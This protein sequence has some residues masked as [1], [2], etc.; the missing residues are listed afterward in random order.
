M[1]SSKRTSILIYNLK[2]LA[3]FVQLFLRSPRGLLGIMLIGVFV[4]V[5]LF[6]AAFTPYDP[7]WGNE[8]AG[9]F[10][11]PAWL[12]A[13]PDNLGGISTS[14]E[15]MNPTLDSGFLDP[16][17][18][19]WNLSAADHANIQRE[20]DFGGRTGVLHI[21]FKRDQIGT[22]YG[23]VTA[24]FSVTFYYPYSGPPFRLSGRVVCLL[25]GT[26]TVTNKTALD[27][28]SRDWPPP[29]IT[30][31]V[32][33]LDVPMKIGAYVEADAINRA[34]PMWPLKKYQ[35]YINAGFEGVTNDDVFMNSSSQWIDSNADTQID[36]YGQLLDAMVLNEYGASYLP[37]KV[38]FP[39]EATPGYYTLGFNVT[40][41][42]ANPNKPVEADVYLD[43][44][45][46][47]LAGT[48]FGILGTDYIGRDLW[49][50][51][52]YGARISLYVGVLSSIMAVSIG[53]VVGLMAGYLGRFVDEFLMRICDVLLVLPG[54]PL[55]IVLVAVL[56]AN[57]DNLIILLGA[58]GWM[59]FARLVRSQVMSLRERP[60][61]EA[62]KAI[63]ASKSHIMFRHILPNVMSLVYVSLAT[64]VPGNIVAEASLGFL[65]FSDPNR[66]SWG[67]MLDNMN[68]NNAY[69]CWWWVLPPGFCIAA[70]AIAFIL[71]GYALDE[72]LNPR[73]R[74]RK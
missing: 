32:R 45:Q 61:V 42:D 43:T 48:S 67:L 39:S 51:L 7:V 68:R 54:L 19:S 40:F 70:I 13:W 64:T 16:T 12:R 1:A 26:V 60:F 28:N 15:N 49:S 57:V 2:R 44:F 50:Q 53:L 69:R 52:V 37:S 18:K 5:S 41:I 17:L 30:V 71:F 59:G 8:M 31:Q 46:F 14:S 9:Y 25:N 38:M 36:S 47:S 63:G 66:M 62:A 22:T 35:S 29:V 55:L 24:G 11:A 56:G 21:S 6:P 10:A 33:T 4:V 58:L 73:L 3:G 72:V 27:L 34:I 20:E 74:L 23:N 65:G